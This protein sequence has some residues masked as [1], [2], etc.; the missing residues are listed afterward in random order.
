[1]IVE[2]T[3]EGRSIARQK[4]GYREGRP[5]KY[6]SAQIDHAIDLL[7]D[8]SYTQVV[9]MTGISRATLAREKRRR[10]AEGKKS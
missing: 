6:S 5:K 1:M 7:S 2:R 3:Q 4:P 9:D 8:H 10:V